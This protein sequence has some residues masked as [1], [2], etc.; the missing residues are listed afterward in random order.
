MSE[1]PERAQEAII[2]VQAE[3][4]AAEEGGEHLYCP[5]C[6]AGME[7]EQRFCSGCG[8][9]AEN[10]DKPPPAEPKSP[11]ELGALSSHNRLTVLLLAILLGW[12]GVH[13]FYVGRALSGALW[14]LTVGF[15]GVGVIYDIVLIATGE[16][17]D[18]DQRRVWHWS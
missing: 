2:E 4:P 6:G 8:W 5:Q 11:R 3:E 17:R 9:D 7:S 1:E 12:L 15:L 13:R 16:F 10:P 18:S 14:L